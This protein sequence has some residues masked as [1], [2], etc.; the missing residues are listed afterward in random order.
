MSIKNDC[1]LLPHIKETI[2]GFNRNSAQIYGWEI[3]KFDIP[4]EWNFSK[5]AG[6]KIAVIDTG[7]DLYHD[8]LKD[9]LLVGKNFINIKKDP[10]DDNGHGTHVSSTIAAS[11]N[12]V[13]IVGVA[14]MSKILPIKALDGDGNGKNDIIASAI[15]WAADA[16]CQFITMSLGSTHD[17]TNIKKAIDYAIKKRCIIFCAAGNSGKNKDIMYPAKY[18]NTISIGSI[19]NN[20]ERSDF[21]CAGESL[22]FLSPGENIIGCVPNNSYAIMSGTSMANPFAVGCSA[23]LYSY[24]KSKHMILKNKEDYINIFK[25]KTL[26]LKQKHFN[27]K[28]YQGYGILQPSC[29][30]ID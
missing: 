27:I 12:G 20:L 14:P 11:D 10:I 19:N 9:N 6:V 16:K 5:G 25:Q 21:S 29:S 13:G 1:S 7:C 3:Q 30:I 8:D 24:A 22:D 28:K 26:K 15:V 4:N 18:T 17:S 23:L 2:F